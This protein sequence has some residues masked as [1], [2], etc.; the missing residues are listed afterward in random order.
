MTTRR[1]RVWGRLL[2]GLLVLVLLA[3][4]TGWWLLGGSRARLDGQH[5]LPGL[6]AS[7]R[8]SRDALGTVTLQGQNRTDLS[9]ALGYVHAQERFFEMDLM[10]DR[11]SVV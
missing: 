4:A 8:I 11:K 10:R 2:V 6:S 7:V 1:W 9:Y 3:F 5:Q